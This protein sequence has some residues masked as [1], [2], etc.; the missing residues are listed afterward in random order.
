MF[1]QGTK[2][3]DSLSL[4]IAWATLG[5]EDPLCFAFCGGTPIEYIFAFINTKRSDL[6]RS[7][8]FTAGTQRLLGHFG[9]SFIPPHDEV[10]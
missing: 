8:A 5:A 7:F 9:D 4:L 1:F 10:T 3:S 2:S 6:S